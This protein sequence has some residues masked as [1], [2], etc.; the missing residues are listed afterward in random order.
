MLD[1][2]ALRYSRW[3]K[4]IVWRLW[5]RQALEQ[6]R[7]FHA[8]VPAE[9]PAIRS[10]GIQAPDP[11]RS[12]SACPPW[13]DR[14][15]SGERVLLFLGRSHAKKGIEH[16]LAAWWELARAAHQAFLGSHAASAVLPCWC[17]LLEEP[18]QAAI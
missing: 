13:V 8:L 3:K 6:T 10:L 15:L 11:T 2:G 12:V 1:S 17:A 14:V 9:L 7:C 16:L 5:E 4:R 18:I